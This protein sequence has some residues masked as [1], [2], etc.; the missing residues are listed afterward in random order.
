MKARVVRL[1]LLLFPLSHA[2]V[3]DRGWT[4]F[5]V[6]VLIKDFPRNTHLSHG[7]SASVQGKATATRALPVLQALLHAETTPGITAVFRYLVDTWAVAKPGRPPLPDLV[8]QVHKDFSAPIETARSGVP[9]QP[10]C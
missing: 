3:N 6:S 2:Q 10:P 5:T 8:R 9:Q 7:K 1:P 4:I